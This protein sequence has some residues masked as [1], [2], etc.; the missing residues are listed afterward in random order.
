VTT[1]LVDLLGETRAQVVDLLRP[2]SLSVAELARRLGL[3]E[4]A[5]RRHL[6]ALERDGLV[7]SETV[8]RNGPGRPGA[9]YALS[10]RGRR[11]YPD[12][13]AELAN[14]LLDELEREYGRGALLAFLRR[15]QQ[16]QAERYASELEGIDSLA[17]RTARLAE[18]LSEDGFMAG[19]DSVAAPGGATVLQL[20]QGHCA[21][22]Q[23]AAAHPE[24][25]AY[26]AALFRDLLGGKL[27]RRQT[28][29]GGAGMCVCTVQSTGVIDGHQG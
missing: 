7:S 24:I 8:R 28:I 20:S 29:A 9:R 22:T 25:C 5:V 10:E 17:E 4:P 6:A 16:R 27:S 11:L 26:E 19:S 1:P 12:R 23:V 13:S 3:T 15:R 2:G 21:I 14:E 18:L